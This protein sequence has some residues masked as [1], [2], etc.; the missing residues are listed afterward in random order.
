MRDVASRIQSV[1]D[2]Y[3]FAKRRVPKGIFQM[4][5]GRSGASVSLRLNE[6][7][8]N[9]VLFRPHA[10]V[11]HPERELKTT[12]LGHEIS[13]PVLLSS[14][15]T[16]K[17]GHVDGEVGVARAAG[18][19][20]TIQIL[21]GATNMP[22]EE[23]V[24]ASGPS[25]QQLY[26]IGGREASAQIIERAKRA[27]ASALVV[28]VDSAA[29]NVG[30]DIPISQRAYMPGGV[31]LRDAVRFAP[32]LLTKPAW[33]LDF[34]RDGIK[35]PTAGMAVGVSRQPRSRDRRRGGRAGPDRPGGR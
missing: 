7:A 32:Q 22:V 30:R 31:T 11:F 10:A 24:A 8:F 23:V 29:P 13:M 21:S 33:A 6:E 2:A 17:V 28:I 5:E 27:G 25:W 9:A 34:V 16:L 26:Y 1:E 12:V 4:F 3:Y 35:T 20:G 14:V 19:A 15:G 18:A